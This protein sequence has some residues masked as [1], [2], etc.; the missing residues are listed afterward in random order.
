MA[1]IDLRKHRERG[2]SLRRRLPQGA[3]LQNYEFLEGP[4]E[5]DAGVIHRVQLSALFMAASRPLVIYYLIYGKT[6]A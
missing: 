3:A 6:Q 1:E 5:H 2:G 4:V